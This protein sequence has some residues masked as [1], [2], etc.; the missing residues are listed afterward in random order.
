MLHTLLSRRYV[1]PGN[2]DQHMLTQF[3]PLTFGCPDLKSS[4]RRVLSIVSKDPMGSLHMRLHMQMHSKEVEDC[5][6]EFADYIINLLE[7]DRAQ[8]HLCIGW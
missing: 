1:A 3:V 7:L 6:L 8:Q 5:F 4:D 2:R